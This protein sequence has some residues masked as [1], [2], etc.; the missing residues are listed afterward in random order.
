MT[1]DRDD[2]G[3]TRTSASDETI[4][5]LAWSADDPQFLEDPARYYR[6][7]RDEAPVLYHAP[8]ESYFLSRFDDVWRATEVWQTFSSESAVARLRHM[9]SMDPPDHDRLRSRGRRARKARQ[10]S[11]ART[12]V[13][14][15]GCRGNAE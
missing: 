13:G 8:T 15:P 1:T 2:G 9:A 5:G 12:P 11:I 10:S 7:L 4:T 6:W 14:R 3:T